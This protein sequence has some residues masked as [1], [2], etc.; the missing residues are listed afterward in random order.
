MNTQSGYTGSHTRREPRLLIVEDDWVSRTFIVDALDDLGTVVT[1]SNTDEAEARLTADPQGYDLVMSDLIAGTKTGLELLNFVRLQLELEAL[2]FLIY[3]AHTDEVIEDKAYQAGATDFIEKPISMARLR[4]RVKASLRLRAAQMGALPRVVSASDMR[5]LISREIE[6]SV[7]GGYFLAIAQL[8]LT[9][10][11]SDRL[12]NVETASDV[13]FEDWFYRRPQV[14]LPMLRTSGAGFW[15]L[16]IAGD[17]A[18]VTEPSKQLEAWIKSIQSDSRLPADIHFLLAQL[19][20]SG[21][22]DGADEQPVAY[23]EVAEQLIAR[24]EDMLARQEAA[25][26]A[27]LSVA[28][29][30]F[31]P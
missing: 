10:A 29:D 30:V 31:S 19:T 9:G 27:Y 7:A 11:E 14:F 12:P 16:S 23:Q 6:R 26:P 3:S 28:R 20:F 2:P 25:K 17:R 22:V 1:C 21:R 5:G 8:R 4:M 24:V 15:L 18:A 13:V